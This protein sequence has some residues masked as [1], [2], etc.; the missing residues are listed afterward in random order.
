MGTFQF[1]N[2]G[3]VNPQGFGGF[4]RPVDFIVWGEERKKEGILMCDPSI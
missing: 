3:E 4:S 1:L 2:Y